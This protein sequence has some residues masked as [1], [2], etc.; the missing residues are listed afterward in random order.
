ML[1]SDSAVSAAPIDVSNLSGPAVSS[2]TAV[3][4]VP[5]CC[6]RPCCFS[7]PAVSGVPAIANITNVSYF[8]MEPG[9]YINA[10]FC[11]LEK[12]HF[13]KNSLFSRIPLRSVPTCETDFS[14]TL[15]ITNDNFIAE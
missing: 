9:K 7:C 12:E 4:D 2:I 11:P 6:C 8:S 5:C 10:Q 14:E 1:V 3:V 13:C 15:G